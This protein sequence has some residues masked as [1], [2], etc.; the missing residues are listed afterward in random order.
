VEDMCYERAPLGRNPL[1]FWAVCPPQSLREMRGGVVGRG[2]KQCPDVF[3]S[4]PVGNSI[5]PR[6]GH[7][8][9]QVT[10]HCG[11]ICV[12]LSLPA[13]RIA[14]AEG[15]DA[16]SGVESSRHAS[17]VRDARASAHRRRAHGGSRRT[18]PMDA[19]QRVARRPCARCGSI[20]FFSRFGTRSRCCISST[21][22]RMCYWPCKSWQRKPWPWLRRS[23]RM[24]TARPSA[25]PFLQLTCARA[26]CQSA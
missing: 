13:H 9:P 20:S 4:L 11:C 10:S 3:P 15:D 16:S 23:T 25:G 1:F 6:V 14:S 26:R 2:T 21:K 8:A 24:H 5:G 19:Q 12:I 7:T 18:W 22:W 17:V